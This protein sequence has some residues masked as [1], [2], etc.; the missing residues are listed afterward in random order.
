MAKVLAIDTSS[1]VASAAVLDDDKV[2]G[3][4]TYNYKKQHSTILIPMIDSLLSSLGLEVSQMDCIACASGPGSFTGLR[5]GAATAKGLCHGAGKPIVGIPTLDGLAFNMAYAAGII[6]PCMDALHDN[7]YTAIYR[8]QGDRLFKIEDYMALSLK[9]LS[10]RLSIYNEKVVFLGDGIFV[11]RDKIT[12]L[13]G[14]KAVFA[15]VHM[16]MQRAS[17]IGAL[18]LERYKRGDTDDYLT[19][20]PFYLRKP[21]AE[22][23]YE[24]AHGG[25]LKP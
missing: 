4:I 12:E 5:I 11:Y 13:L 7:V 3:E 20:A 24:K 9:E 22:R 1:M 10:E 15:P 21:Q 19:F 16:N 2:L 8:W 14:E 18:A 23:E 17:S 25:V 6:C